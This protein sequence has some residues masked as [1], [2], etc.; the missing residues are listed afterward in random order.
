MNLTQ[1]QF[2]QPRTLTEG[3]HDWRPLGDICKRCEMP[4]SHYEADKAHCRGRRMHNDPWPPAPSS[5]A[6]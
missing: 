3:N 2:K 4:W 6:R 5:L 1:P